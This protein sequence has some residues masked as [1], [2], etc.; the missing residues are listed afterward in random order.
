MVK[1]TIPPPPPPPGP[2]PRTS[3][4]RSVVYL[5][6]FWDPGN[7]FYL[8]KWKES[9]CIW[10]RRCANSKKLIWFTKGFCKIEYAPGYSYLP[11]RK[12][13]YCSQEAFIEQLKS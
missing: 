4:P 6:T 13:W 2:P 10:P 3:P 12:S 9:F 1:S 7:P 5:D 11:I 8:A